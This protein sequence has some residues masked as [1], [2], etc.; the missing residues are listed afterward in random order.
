MHFSVWLAGLFLGVSL[1]SPST[2]AQST[3]V[4]PRPPKRECQAKPP[5]PAGAHDSFGN[6]DASPVRLC[7]PGKVFV[8][9]YISIY[10]EGSTA[11][12]QGSTRVAH[13][14]MTFWHGGTIGQHDF[15]LP[16]GDGSFYFAGPTSIGVDANS[17]VY[18][19]VNWG[20]SRPF[21]IN[22]NVSGHYE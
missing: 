20:E 3:V 5:S 6:F 8:I 9:D 14:I 10:F 22:F 19:S 2:L 15:A 1:L 4:H 21:G 11:P 13:A 18:L 12:F 17:S 16:G 7:I